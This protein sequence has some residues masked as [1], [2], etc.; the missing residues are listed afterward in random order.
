MRTLLFCFEWTFVVQIMAYTVCPY[1]IVAITDTDIDEVIQIACRY[2]Q[3]DTLFYYIVP[4]ISVV[5][6]SLQGLGD[7]ITPIVSSGL[8]LAG[9]L[10]FALILTPHW[11]YWAVIWSEPVVWIIMVIPLII[12]MFLRLHKPLK[13][14]RAPY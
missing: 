11:G 6:N 5:R 1:L 9:K 12:S 4:V 10:G 2:Q 14:S 7:H 3:V 13:A 8:E